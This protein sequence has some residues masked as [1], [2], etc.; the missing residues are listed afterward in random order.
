MR[1]WAVRVF[2]AVLCVSGASRAESRVRPHELVQVPTDVSGLR[3]LLTSP[4]EWWL[5]PVP[6]MPGARP[7][8]RSALR[9]SSVLGALVIT[10]DL[11]L[12]GTSFLAFRLIPTRRALGGE[13]QAPIVLR[14]RLL[15]TTWYGVDALMRF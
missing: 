5:G 1:G 3:R 13:V 12:P 11:M 6:G 4:S 14:P 8:N 9:F 2:L 10:R 7:G 15:A